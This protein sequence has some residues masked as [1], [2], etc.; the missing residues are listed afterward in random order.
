MRA[1]PISTIVLLLSG[2]IGVSALGGVALSA[3]SPGKPWFLLGFECVVLFASVF[4]VLAGRK[5]FEQGASLTLVCIAGAWG[6]CSL[7]GYLGAGKAIVL[8]GNR[9]IPLEPLLFGRCIAAG[10]LALLAAALVLSRNA[11]KSVPLL[12][13]GL[14]MLVP[15]MAMIA[16][17]WKMRAQIAA[18][19]MSGVLVAV[20]GL[21]VVSAIIGLIAA[22]IHASIRA[23][24]VAEEAGQS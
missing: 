13:K 1:Q 10:V 5:W 15:G 9:T 18:T 19:N 22:G 17:V 11:P 8:S 20:V 21:I 7:F 6:V 14:A 16:I 4:G 2:L 24:E 23:F 3:L 12:V